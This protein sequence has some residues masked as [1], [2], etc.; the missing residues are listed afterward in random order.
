MTHVKP[1]QTR[2]NA[3]NDWAVNLT[4]RLSTED[5][6]T[7]RKKALDAGMSQSEYVR[8][9]IRHARIRVSVEVGDE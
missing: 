5:Q 4:I 7:L 9:L 6:D 3:T 8:F 2:P 1:K